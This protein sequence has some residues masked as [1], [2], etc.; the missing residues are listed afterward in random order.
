MTLQ[1][2]KV[3]ENTQNGS[4]A[5]ENPALKRRLPVDIP[6]RVD[7]LVGQI[8]TELKNLGRDGVVLDRATQE[9]L[10]S[11][12]NL[13]QSIEKRFIYNTIQ[14]LKDCDARQEQLV[15]KLDFIQIALD[16]LFQKQPN[17]CL[18]K[19][20]RRNIQYSMDETD[21]PVKGFWK[22]SLLKIIHLG[23]TPS[24]LM[25]GLV[26]A[27]P[28]YLG[29]AFSSIAAL[30]YF[31]RFVGI[32]PPEN[33]VNIQP[34]G[35]VAMSR[36]YFDTLV[37]L[38]LVG[39]AGALGSII[40]ILTRIEEYQNKEYDDSILPIAIGACKPLIGASFGILLF[41]ISCS[42]I[43]PLQIAQNATQK[44]T[45]GFTF[46]LLHSLLDS[47]KGLQKILSVEL[48]EAYLVTLAPKNQKIKSNPC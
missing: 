42:T 9:E 13:L 43:S 33:S 14:G 20:I 10:S 7:Y 22:N 24:K 41:T 3:S 44:S 32:I 37:L 4:S 5:V 48:R 36:E 6:S 45:K 34:Q 39:S 40:S 15:A 28:L 19:R 35:R 11:V 21:N 26:F 2:A 46:F 27:L 25:V 12:I 47:A 30:T 18:A 1:E 31:S 38:A 8:T 16:A 29:V 17:I 23:S